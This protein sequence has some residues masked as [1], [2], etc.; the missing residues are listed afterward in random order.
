MNHLITKRRHR[1]WARAAVALATVGILSVSG[2]PQLQGTA[3]AAVKAQ[4]CD[5]MFKLSGNPTDPSKLPWANGDAVRPK[6]DW[7]SYGFPNQRKAM[8]GLTLPDD[9]A[10]RDKIL[11]KLDQPYK[12]YAEGTPERVYA[13]YKDYLSRNGGTDAKYG[14]FQNWLNEAYIEV[15]GRNPR[16]NAYHA[17]I[18]KDLGLTGP[19]WICEE[20]VK[21]T[22]PE[23]GKTYE[24][25]FDAFNRKTQEAV[26][27]KSGGNHDSEQAPKDRAFLKDPKFKDYKLRYAFGQPQS[28]DTTRFTN[29]LKQLG[30]P[31]RVTTYEH[32]STPEAEFEPGKYTAQDTKKSIGRS[33]EVVR[34]SPAT[35]A[36][37]KRTMDRIRAND[38]T[39][40]R[41]RGPGGVDFS[42]LELRYVGK[43]VKGQGLNYSFAAKKVDESAGLG[44]GGQEKAE[45]VS[46]S[47]FTWLA[48]TPEKFWVNLNPDQP[49]KIMD[50][51]FGK[52]DA[53]RALLQADLEMK[54]DYARDMDPRAGIGKE[55]W[56]KLR[57]ENIPCTHG[58]RNWIVP[59]PAVVREQD[60]GLYILDAP[61]KVNSVP[62]DF[63]TPSPNGDCNLTE[64]QHKRVQ[65]LLDTMIVP[66][67]E[68]KVNTD[69][70][71]TD[72]RR[73]YNSRVAAE[74]IRQQDA[75]SPTDY[76]AII[77]S[78]KVTDWP[79]RGKNTSWIPEQTYKE[80]VKSFTQGDY[81]YPC[82]KAGQNATCVMGGV[83]FSK[84]PKKN[85]S[86]A[87]FAA[88]HK[89]LSR[90]TDISVKTMTDDA[91][92]KDLLAL[93]GNTT[94]HNG[95]GGGPTPT[96]TPT[97][98]HTSP[99]S[100]P[101]AGHTPN[102]G[103][104]GQQ[105]PSG[106]RGGLA[107]TGTQI[108]GIAGAALALL[109]AGVGLVWW[110]RRRTAGAE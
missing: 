38:P 58:V 92:N 87:Q 54:H 108:A 20:T 70:K 47:F 57:A 29:G 45:L 68:K 88:E 12:K 14:G 49:D 79:L 37:M 52:T 53:G 34:Q 93:G 50:K 10:D 81:S 35:P 27:V 25:R 7:D 2:L 86:Q 15:Y 13:T 42:T 21:V 75:K 74:W 32:V 26:E 71:Y 44:Y 85:I 18:V 95:G 8:D 84:A 106:P 66:D 40:L 16:G 76:H 30:G 51:T 78:N 67:V 62:Q 4:R 65:N 100:T 63:K 97:P 5:E 41:V 55:F 59:K 28:E 98:T 82:E 91:E 102:P 48:L 83:D 110:R 103:H 23:T 3:D 39:G 73:V 99:P 22:D 77:N 94:S 104:T 11:G 46:D 61:L 36:D 64:A 31:G 9:P 109:A 69:A 56:D 60:G 19:D 33:S 90:T 17:K 105:Q 107:N 101:P 1:V 72:L 96:P 43:P 6:A 89:Y 80:Y 24:R